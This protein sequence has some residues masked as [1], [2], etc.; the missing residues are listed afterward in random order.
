MGE[1]KSLPFI[2]P[3]LVPKFKEL[4]NLISIPTILLYLGE[5]GILKEPTYVSKIK[6]V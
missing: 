1:G 2:A 4:W 6:N 5:K 3:K